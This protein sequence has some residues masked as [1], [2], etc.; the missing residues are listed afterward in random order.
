MIYFIIKINFSMWYVYCNLLILIIIFKKKCIILQKK[1][2]NWPLY[3]S[4]C[5]MKPGRSHEQLNMYK[6]SLTW[7][8]IKRRKMK[9]HYHSLQ[10]IKWKYSFSYEDKYFIITSITV[11]V[12]LI[13]NITLYSKITWA[14][15]INYYLLK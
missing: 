1:N 7:R 13:I 2:N 4:S 10:S 6:V 8:R 9:R 11:I 14:I 5:K 15:P 3:A 12:I